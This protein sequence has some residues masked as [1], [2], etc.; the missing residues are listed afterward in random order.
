V[1]VTGDVGVGV[2]SVE[3]IHHRKGYTISSENRSR[4]GVDMTIDDA[5]GGTGDGR[6][7]ALTVHVSAGQLE[8]DRMEAAA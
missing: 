8:I 3:T 7:I 6:P 5:I 1:S 4:G 2:Y